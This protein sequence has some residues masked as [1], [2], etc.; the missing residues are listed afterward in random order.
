MCSEA[1]R[2]EVI[3]ELHGGT[4]G[5]PRRVLQ[6]HR[7]AS[8]CA[9]AVRPRRTCR[10]VRRRRSGSGAA[11]RA[12]LVS[13]SA[14][15]AGIGSKTRHGE[16]GSGAPREAATSNPSPTYSRMSS[17]PAAR[18]HLLV[19]VQVHQGACPRSAEILTPGTGRRSRICARR[20]GANPNLL[21]LCHSGTSLPDA[22]YAIS[23]NGRFRLRWKWQLPRK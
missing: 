13:P 6:P 23:M 17:R 8:R 18:S 20:L 3:A 1:L 19:S 9:A 22:Q 10:A 5:R 12:F 4:L 15:P 2:L 11:S 14:S 21:R 16:P 7:G